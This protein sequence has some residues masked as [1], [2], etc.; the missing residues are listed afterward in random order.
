[1]STEEQG[2]AEKAFKNFGKR[3]D[4]FIVEL[5]EASERL[6]HEYQEKY[7]DL[8]ASASK[9]KEEVKNKERWQEVEERLEKAGEEFKRAF[10]AAFK[11]RKEG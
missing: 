11:K 8:K 6:E 2:K 5:K 1:M 3:V 4:D 7:S 9:L 10:E